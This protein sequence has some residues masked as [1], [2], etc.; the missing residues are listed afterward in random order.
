MIQMPA[1]GKSKGYKYWRKI[2]SFNYMLIVND[3]KLGFAKIYRKSDRW[4]GH[5]YTEL[6][7]VLGAKGQTFSTFNE[8]QSWVN[9]QRKE[10]TK[11]IN[12]R[13]RKI[14]K[15]LRGE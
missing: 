12:R 10:V 4:F 9:K 7:G 3:I 5:I 1:K 11:K 13:Q 8:A 14:K 2:D 15:I 6:K